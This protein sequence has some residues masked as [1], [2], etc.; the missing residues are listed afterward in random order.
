MYFDKIGSLGGIMRKKFLLAI[1]ILISGLTLFA[2]PVPP[3]GTGTETDP[4]QI[5]TF[6][7][8]LWVS[9]SQYQWG[10]YFIQTSDINA[11]DTRL[12]LGGEGF[13]PI[14]AQDMY[15]SFTGSYNGQG[16]VIDSLYINAHDP[17]QD[18]EYFGL[19]G[20]T[21]GAVVE[22][23][24]LTNV[25]IIGFHYTAALIG[26]SS[27]TIVSNCYCTGRVTSMS[28]PGGLVCG[29]ENTTLINSYYSYEQMF[30]NGIHFKTI[31]ALSL[32]LFQTW[33]SNGLHLEIDDYLTS[34]NGVYQISSDV[35][36]AKLYAFGQ[37]NHSFE[38]VGDIDLSGDI[39]FG[40]PY[41]EGSFS[42]NGHQIS[43][44]RQFNNYGSGGLFG[45]AMNAIIDGLVLTDVNISS[46]NSNGAICGISMSSTLS[47]CTSN[48]QVFGY[49]QTGGIVGYA[50]DSSLIGCQN[51]A[52]VDGSGS[53]GGVAGYSNYTS[54][55]ECSSVS[56]V[57]NTGYIGG[58]IGVARNSSF[59][60]CFCNSIIS[61]CIDSSGGFVSTSYT[62]SYTD[63]Y[64]Q[65]RYTDLIAIFGG[66]ISAGYASD[67]VNC[68]SVTSGIDGAF[69]FGGFSFGMFDLSTVTNCFWNN[70]LVESIPNWEDMSTG[71]TTAEMQSYNTYFNAGW[72]FIGETDNGTDDVWGINPEE[73]NG[74]PFL[75]WQG[76][77]NNHPEPVSNQ[78]I[79]AIVT[80]LNGNYPNPF[81]PTT[82]IKFS[83]AEK[84]NVE[85]TVYN[86]KGQKVKTLTKDFLDKGEH[87]VIWNGDDELGKTVSSGMYFY[88]LAIAGKTIASNKC[89]LLK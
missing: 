58:F 89:M 68:Y 25:E 57:I 1:L 52:T 5:A 11:A 82:T 63:C 32:Q 26:Y 16:H 44:L 48:G 64:T 8:L 45:C 69:F 83:L 33:I 22:N 46:Y 78:T 76:Y 73:N 20:K 67:C 71:L 49:W 74:Y 37:G 31:G 36:L 3:I 55:T 50:F 80:G 34:V 2:D 7:N 17:G 24:A 54:F 51:S 72:D 60:R 87:S 6:E 12:I 70:E 23:L 75:A 86:L 43:G 35:D 21:E 79:T 40:I 27:N 10:A 77:V 61:E 38:L 39:N 19:F 18:I 13:S 42:G 41:F 28:I 9:Y 29:N 88:R 85:L 30:L 15:Y 84:G 81:N 14:G 62:C 4:Y 53:S 59:T 56:Q 47:N 66:F 65:N